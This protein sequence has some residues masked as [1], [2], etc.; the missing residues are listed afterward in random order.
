ME[1]LTGLCMGCM[2]PLDGRQIC[3]R[4]SYDNTIPNMRGTLPAG[5]M[6]DGGYMVGKVVRRND[7][8]II[9]LGLHTENSVKV[10]IEEFCPAPLAERDWDGCGI[11]VTEENRIRYKTLFSDMGDRWKRLGKLD[12]RCVIKIKE[13]ISQYGTIYCITPYLPLHTLEM[14]L[15]EKGRY[16]WSEAKAAFLPLFTMVSNLHNQGLTHCGISPENIL[17]GRRGAF[18]L[19]GFALPELRTEDSGL[20]PELY[21]GYSAPEQYSKNLWQGEWTDVYSLGAVLYHTLTGVSPQPALERAK[22]DTMLE[23]ATAEPAIPGNVSEAL[24]RAMAL[25]KQK[26]LQSVDE[27]TAA[28]LKENTSNTAVF[29][30]EPVRTETKPKS[31]EKGLPKRTSELLFL[32]I[33]GI[34]LVLN[35]V[36]GGMAVTGGAATPTIPES[37][38][39]QAPVELMDYHLAGTYIK[40]IQDNRTLYGGLQYETQYTYNEEYPKDIVFAQSVARGEPIPEN[41]TVILYVSSGSQFITMPYLIGSSANFASKTLTDLGVPFEFV[42]DYNPESSGIADTVVACNKG[43]GAKLARETDQVVLTIKQTPPT[44]IPPAASE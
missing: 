33:L 25:D 5:T 39:S 9:Y 7:L 1:K 30:S 21:A 4:C 38:S 12:G 28:L 41:R 23:A 40:T 42:Y 15:E 26:R 27:L 13:L 3:S 22:R 18:T 36:L 10:Y 2:S 19:T 44:S 11:V 37:V 20:F 16:T 43:F 8:T 6:L 31:G 29:H 17:V 35:L 32:G 14:Q 34:S 24:V